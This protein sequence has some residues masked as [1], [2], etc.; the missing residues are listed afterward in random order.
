MHK[1][2]GAAAIG[3]DEAKSAICIEEFDPPSWHDIN[4]CALQPRHRYGAV[5]AGPNHPSLLCSLSS[6]PFAQ[7]VRAKWQKSRSANFGQYRLRDWFRISG[8][9]DLTHSVT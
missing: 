5:T 8:S 9:V 6:L 3:H 2:I 7:H 4:L 1:N